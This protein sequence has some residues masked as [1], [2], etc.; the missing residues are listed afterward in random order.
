MAQLDARPGTYALILHC[1][2]DQV[3]DVGR[4]GKLSVRPG[5]HVYVG[6]AFG[7]G[8]LASRV[9]RHRSPTKKLHWHIDHLTTITRLVEV[10]YTRDPSRRECQWADTL[11]WMPGAS[12]P[13]KRFGASDCSCLSHLYFFAAKPSSNGFRRRVLKL[14]PDHGSVL[15]STVQCES[16]DQVRCRVT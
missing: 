13:L 2:R 8:G 11:R 12:I 6:S 10:W 9:A 16:A 5:F 1:L 14:I 3:V 15:C 7:P 4:I